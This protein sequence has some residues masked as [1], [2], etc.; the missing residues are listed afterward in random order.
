MGRSDDRPGD[1]SHPKDR[2]EA[3]EESGPRTELEG[4]VL[5]VSSGPSSS[6]GSFL[7][8][9]RGRALIGSDETCELVISDSSVSR[10]HVEISVRTDGLMVKDLGSTNGTLYHGQRIESA[11]LK[12]GTRLQLGR[13]A[14]DMLPLS[15]SSGIPPSARTSYGESIGSSMPMR[16]L[17]TLLERLENSDAPV[18]IHGET[19][20]G[21]ELIAQAIHQRSVRSDKPYVVIDCGSMLTDLIRGEIFGYRKGAFTGADT[22]RA[23]AFEVATGGTVRCVE[24]TIQAPATRVAQVIGMALCETLQASQ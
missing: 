20:T 24:C 8:L 7:K 2:T 12:T 13:C 19:G 14:L 1:P 16:R 4:C 11:L 22:D 9:E 23:G 6:S 15:G 3:L 5:Y 10:H 21:K 17:F 18:L